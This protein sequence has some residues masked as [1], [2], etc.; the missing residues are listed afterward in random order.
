MPPVIAWI[1]ANW[2]AAAIGTTVVV[3]AVTIAINWEKIM[4][5]LKGKQIAVLGE[6]RVGKT[7][8][9]TFL[10]TGEIPEKYDATVEQLKV[11]R[12]HFKLEELKL[13]IKET[14]DVAGDE[15]ALHE[16]KSLCKRSDIIL[17][18]F[19][20]DWF[21]NDNNKYKQ[22]D[23]INRLKRDTN[24]IV[25]FLKGRADKP[26]FFIVGTHTDMDQ[27]CPSSNDPKF[28]QYHDDIVA[29]IRG[30][31]NLAVLIPNNQ[32]VTSILVGSM[33]TLSDT[34]GLVIRLF[35]QIIQ[36]LEK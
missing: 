28:V 15:V 27:K 26:L 32:E 14:A 19:R 30:E 8:L 22:L 4:T 6:R 10:T 3:A 18:L 25:H 31:T 21:N 16:W 24:S 7:H 20:T 9:I 23:T 2:I 5:N 35:G 1:V 11:E 17:Y 13:R 34:Q 33:K 12:K 29:K 36:E